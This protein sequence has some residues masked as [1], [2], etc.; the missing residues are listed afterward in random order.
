[1]RIEEKENCSEIRE[2]FIGQSKRIK[3]FHSHPF[4]PK[5]E[6]LNSD[7]VNGSAYKM[8]PQTNHHPTL[9]QTSDDACRP[10][11]NDDEAVVNSNMRTSQQS[12]LF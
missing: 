3:V 10:D 7:N 1:M 6:Q 11:D 2:N 9:V 8:N 4:F 5:L 12:P